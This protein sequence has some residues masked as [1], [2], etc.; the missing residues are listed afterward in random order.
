M[1]CKRRW[2]QAIHLTKRSFITVHQNWSSI[3]GSQS[4]WHR[5]I[6][7][8]LKC[9]RYPVTLGSLHR[10]SRLI[11]TF[12]RQFMLNNCCL[13][14]WAQSTC[15]LSMWK[16]LWNETMV[17]PMESSYSFGACSVRL[18]HSNRSL[19]NNI[20]FTRIVLLSLE[21]LNLQSL[22]DSIIFAVN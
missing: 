20:S 19:S 3:K 22:T 14:G 13:L 16:V 4:M 17:E 9:L 6:P 5:F 1:G 21:D 7:P 11:T 8:K 12:K 15:L 10:Q 2:P 18:G